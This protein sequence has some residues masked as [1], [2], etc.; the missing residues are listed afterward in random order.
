MRGTDN[1]Y[2]AT[3]T[4]HTPVSPATCL[5]ACYAMSGTEIAYALAAILILGHKVG[6]CAA[7]SITIKRNL[8]AVCT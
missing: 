5:R 2:A 7:S 4:H 1:G 3:R 8:P 6:L